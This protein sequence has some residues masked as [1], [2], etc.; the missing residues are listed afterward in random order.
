MGRSCRH[1]RADS[2]DGNWFG[3]LYAP[4][5]SLHAQ[6]IRAH[7]AA[8]GLQRPGGRDFASTFHS[9]W[10]PLMF[11]PRED[12]LRL[13]PEIILCLSGIL[14]MLVEPFLTRARKSVLVTLAALGSGL[15]LASTI[16]PAMLPGTAFSGLLRI[17]GF[18]VFVHVVVEAVAFL[19]I[20]GSADYLDREHIQHGE[21]YALILFAT[22]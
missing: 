8:P 19:V 21:Y 1:G 17:D 10:P 20:I 15:A 14:L 9:E 16:Y 5:G 2:L 13:L 12:V 6:Y 7:A 18:S 22:V 11:P 3:G 4:H